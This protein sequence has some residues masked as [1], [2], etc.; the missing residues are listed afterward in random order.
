MWMLCQT[1]TAKQPQQMYSATLVFLT[2]KLAMRQDI[3]SCQSLTI[4]HDRI[5]SWKGLG[6][7]AATVY[8]QKFVSSSV[9]STL[10]IVG[11]LGCISVL[12]I[13]IPSIL[14]A[15]TFNSSTPMTAG[16]FGIPEFIDLTAV[17][18]VHPNKYIAFMLM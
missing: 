4:T 15:E 6:S 1:I 5:S 7:A 2:Q 8:K 18:Y 14:S 12:H 17:K 13:T 11:Y 10:S 3:Q 9:L 16:T